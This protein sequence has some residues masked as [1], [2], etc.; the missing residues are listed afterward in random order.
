MAAPIAAKKPLGRRAKFPNDF[1]RVMRGRLEA[2]KRFIGS[3]V[4]GAN[5]QSSSGGKPMGDAAVE[6]HFR[7]KSRNYSAAGRGMFAKI[8]SRLAAIAKSEL[9]KHFENYLRMRHLPVSKRLIKET[10][11]SRY[12][13][14]DVA[15]NPEWRLYEKI[16]LKKLRRRDTRVMKA[17][18]RGFPAETRMGRTAKPKKKGKKETGNRRD[19]ETKEAPAKKEEVSP[20]K[21]AM[22]K[23][24]AENPPGAA[25]FLNGLLEKKRITEKQV[26]GFAIEGSYT[27]RVFRMALD[28]GLGRFGEG[29]TSDLAEI[30]LR[31]GSEGAH[32]AKAQ[33][34]A[35]GLGYGKKI[36]R[37]LI[38]TGLVLT[39][40]G[41]MK[42][43]VFIAQPEYLGEAIKKIYG[44]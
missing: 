9:P 32:G 8:S 5:L 17:S 27:L 1:A 13:R 18:L 28:A 37:G 33:K 38:N 35:G 39:R 29:A 2:K 36:Y 16:Y 31:I 26:R 40:H 3:A 44:K 25:D 34:L 12:V 10:F 19:A 23:I 6:A 42:R 24:R 41:Y 15:G 30:L 4:R 14:F 11:S 22:D 21:Q 7:A 20:L 43:D